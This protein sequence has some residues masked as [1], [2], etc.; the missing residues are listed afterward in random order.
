M[1]RIPVTDEWTE[2]TDGTETFD[3]L[4]RIGD[5]VRIALGSTSGRTFANATPMTRGQ[6][7][8]VPAGVAM[9]GI[10]Q[11]GKSSTAWKEDGFSL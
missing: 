2:I 9:S 3:T 8:N 5:G 11:D 6:L 7:V 4:V 10:C 1:A